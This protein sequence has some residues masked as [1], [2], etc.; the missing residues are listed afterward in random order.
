MKIEIWSDVMCPFCYIGKRKFE[1]ALAKFPHQDKLEIEWKSYQLTP[2]MVTQPDKNINEFLAEHK[3]MSLAAAEEMNNRVTEMARSVGLDYQMNKSI[4]ANSFQAH[5]FA[6]F[7][8]RH[9]K[10]V[11]AEEALF[12]AYFTDGENI[13]DRAT[14]LKLGEEIGLDATALAE[15]LQ[16]DEFAGEVKSDIDEA[17]KIGVRGVPFFVFNRAYAISGAQEPEAFLNTLGKSYTEWAKENEGSK[18]NITSG[19]SCAPDGTCD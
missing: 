14:L 19:P 7:A 12:R 13:D 18:L 17:R 15:S 5:Q 8:K 16:N 3:G 1:T 2:D 9:G 11:E 4:V 6:H 10:Q